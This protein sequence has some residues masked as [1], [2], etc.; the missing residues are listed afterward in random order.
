MGER[1]CQGVVRVEVS[2]KDVVTGEG[3]DFI[4]PWHVRWGGRL[5]PPPPEA[6]T[7]GGVGQVFT[8]CHASPGGNALTCCSVTATPGLHTGGFREYLP[9]P[10]LRQLL[11]GSLNRR[12]EDL[13]GQSLFGAGDCYRFYHL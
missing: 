1:K 6:D 5:T 7:G 3:T 4:K 11:V 2:C 8:I 13:T 9:L 12:L 10:C